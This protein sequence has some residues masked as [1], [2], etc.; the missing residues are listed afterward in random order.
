MTYSQFLR[1]SAEAEGLWYNSLWEACVCKWA[2]LED[3]L[4]IVVNFLSVCVR[5]LVY[6]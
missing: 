1:A 6:E 3:T 4:I 5:M 2:D